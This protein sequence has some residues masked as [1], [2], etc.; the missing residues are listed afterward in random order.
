MKQEELD[1]NFKSALDGM[2]LDCRTTPPDKNSELKIWIIA[3][4]DLTLS[5][6][7]FGAQTGHAAGTC[8]VL[9]DRRNNS[10]L[11]EY[12]SLGQPKITVGVDNEAELIKCVKLCHEEMLVAVLVQDAGRTELDGKTFTVAAVGPCLRSELPKAVKRLQTLKAPE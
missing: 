6:G 5:R 7:K 3:R 12:L 10:N 9:S 11:N 8:M 2:V 1:F 4:K